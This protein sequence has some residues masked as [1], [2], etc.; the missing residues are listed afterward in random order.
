MPYIKPEARELL[1][2][3]MVP[4]ASGELNYKITEL[5]KAY[6]DHHSLCYQT[7]NDV[8]GALEGAK[9]EYYRRVVSKYEDVKIELNG[10]VY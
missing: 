9:L 2:K 4:L 1:S 7:I 6:T 5:L 10:D 8:V 3:G